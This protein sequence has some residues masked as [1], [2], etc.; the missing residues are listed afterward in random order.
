MGVPVTVR[1][2][3]ATAPGT[4]GELAQGML[5]GTLCMGTCLIDMYS[6]ATVELRVGNGGVEGPADS[7]KA[8]QAVEETLE[9]LGETGLEGRLLLGS[10]LPRG[11][12]DPSST[13]DVSAAI[14]ATATALGRE[15]PPRTVAGIALGVEPSAGVMIPDIA[16]FDHREGKVSKTLGPPPPTRVEV[17]DF[18]GSMDTLEFNRVDRESELKSL[19]PQMSQAVSLIQDGIHRQDPLLI[20]KGATI[21]AVA[22]QRVLFNPNL[23]VAMDLSIRVGAVDVNLALSG[24]VIGLLFPDEDTFAQNAAAKA[25]EELPGLQAAFHRRI[26]GGGVSRC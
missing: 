15:L 23:D 22:N 3:S 21:S 14:C 16:V 17:L 4:C 20:G 26:I 13:A 5:D 7:P 1:R 9:Y 10:P 24:T 2:A 12:G 6:V 8:R 18:G 19:G 25:S 11:S